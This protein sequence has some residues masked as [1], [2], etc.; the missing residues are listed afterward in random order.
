MYLEIV[1][2]DFAV[3]RVFLGILRDFVEVPEFR[4][5]A[6]ARNIRSPVK[7]RWINYYFSVLAAYRIRKDCSWAILA[8]ASQMP[9]DIQYMCLLVLQNMYFFGVYLIYNLLIFCADDSYNPPWD[10][11]KVSY[12]CVPSV[13]FTSDASFVVIGWIIILQ[14]IPM[15]VDFIQVI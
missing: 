10:G 7:G 14:D 1:L 15:Y 3:F 2:A 6:T 4:G 12:I 9:E 11:C 8:H 13:K 5:S